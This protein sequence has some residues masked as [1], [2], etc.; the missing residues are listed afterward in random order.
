MQPNPEVARALGRYRGP[1]FAL[2]PGTILGLLF[3]ALLVVA[4]LRHHVQTSDWVN[5]L[6]WCTALAAFWLV[7]QTIVSTTGIRLVWRF[8]FIPWSDVARIYGSG[9][10]DPNLLIGL[11]NGKRLSVPGLPPDRLP[12]ILILARQ[13]AGAADYDPTSEVQHPSGGD[14]P[15][16]SD[17]P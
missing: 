9:P 14:K 11:A 3:L 7:P 15:F 6:V 10:G 8:R 12:G 17:Q 5:G 13:L 1:L 4:I 16:G 2:I